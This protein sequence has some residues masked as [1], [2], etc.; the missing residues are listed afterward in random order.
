[1]SYTARI[2]L[3]PASEADL[4]E[5]LPLDEVPAVKVYLGSPLFG[6]RAPTWES[7]SLTQRQAQDY[8]LRIF[9]PVVAGAARE[10]PAVLTE[11]R[12]QGCLRRG[13]AI[14]LFGF[15]AGGTAVLITLLLQCV[16]RLRKRTNRIAIRGR[17][18]GAGDEATLRLVGCL[19]PA[20]RAER[21]NSTR[22]THRDVLFGT[23]AASPASFSWSGRQG[24]RAR[25]YRCV[26]RF[27]AT[28]LRARRGCTKAAVTVAP[29]VLS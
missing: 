2:A 1:M 22:C 15:S 24:H 6:A 4:M 11:L 23:A 10:L 29:G 19:A 25:R 7:D 17:R 20:C 14:G 16:L 12:K 26:G 27:A 8:A 28:G 5:D 21:C 13:D 9:E 18:A 3:S